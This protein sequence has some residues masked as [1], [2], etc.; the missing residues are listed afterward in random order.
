MANKKLNFYFFGEI[1]EYDCYNPSYVCSKEYVSEILYLIA[2]NEPISISKIEIAEFLNIKKETVE[3]NIKNLELINAIEI[4]A[5]GY[6]IKFP[7]FLEED[8]IEMEN[9][10]NNIG[11]LI[12][13]KIIEIKDTLY[14]KVSVLICSKY[15]SYERI[16]YHIICD[17]IFD[18]IAFEFFTEKTIFCSSKKQPGGRDYIIIAYQDSEL[19]EKYSNKLLCSSNNYRTYDFTFNSF[20][21]SNGLRNDMFR[22]FRLVQ[23]SV[24][25]AS[26]F[27]KVNEAYNR[28]LD[29]IN[30]EIAYECGIL[31]YDIIN[32]DINYNQLSEKEKNLIELLNELD[33]IDINDVDNTISINIPIFLNFEISSVIR[34]LSDIILISIFPL[35]KEVFDNFEVNASKLSPIRHNVDIKETANELWHQIFGATNEYLVKEGFVALPQNIDGQGRYLRS[36]TVPNY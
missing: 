27:N 25:N 12:G 24:D 30:R 32:K 17:K 22:F 10:L 28:I 5:G 33:Y 2:Q 7:A 35:V 20:G 15:H 34:E 16:L 18:D 1:G 9:Y 23:K 14:K 36:L 4:K 29:S 21:D 11:E 8:I 19:V 6:R 26:P 3:Y 31:I 13:K